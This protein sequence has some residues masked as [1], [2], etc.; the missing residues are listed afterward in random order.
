MSE[1]EFRFREGSSA[2][3]PSLARL[4]GSF[5]DEWVLYLEQEGG[6]I[7]Q[8]VT[9]RWRKTKP[10]G[11]RQDLR[12][13]LE[14][15]ATELDRSE[16][17]IIAEHDGRIAGY[18]MLKTNWN[19]TTEIAVVIVDLAYRRRGLGRLFLQASESYARERSL[20][21]IQWEAQTDNRNAIEFAISHGFRIAGYHDA[22][23]HNRG[24]ERQNAGDFR[25]LAIFLT[26]EL[27]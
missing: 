6:P 27:D 23:Y 7:E 20:R 16:R 18:L 3:L 22:L 15:L 12:M 8:T 13:D 4:E 19:R 25:G 17:L 1:S 10:D 26:R 11:S 24:F 21:A 9:R 14:E 2:D 5:S